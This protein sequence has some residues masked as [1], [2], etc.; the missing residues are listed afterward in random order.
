MTCPVVQGAP[1]LTFR[2]ENAT[3]IISSIFAIAADFRGEFTGHIFRVPLNNQQVWMIY[4]S[5]DIT[6]HFT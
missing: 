3:P 2:F 1:Y 4:A 6:L 5:R